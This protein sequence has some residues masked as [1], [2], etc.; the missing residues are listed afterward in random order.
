MTSPTA[1]APDDSANR[2]PRLSVI[3]PFHNE[4]RQLSRCLE[5]L[6]ASSIRDLEVIL[7]DD[8]SDDGSTQIAAGFAQRSHGRVRL[9]RIETN[10][11]P[12]AARNR[13]IA[14]SSGE[15]VAFVDAD[16]VVGERS[17]ECL[18][19]LL[20]AE[21]GTGGVIGTV[22]PDTDGGSFASAYNNLFRRHL[23]VDLPAHVCFFFS[24]FGALRRS[25]IVAAGPFNEAYRSADIE[26]VEYGFRLTDLGIPIA[27]CPALEV[28]HIKRLRWTGLLRVRARRAYY[29]TQFLLD[30]WRV[31]RVHRD[32]LQGLD[33]GF[34]TSLVAATLEVPTLVMAL[35]DPAAF[36][37]V[38]LATLI[39]VETT[40]QRHFLRFARRHRSR[41]VVVAVAIF[42]RFDMWAVAL[43]AAAGGT[44]FLMRTLGLRSLRRSV[45]REPLAS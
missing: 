26:D 37:F 39:L 19:D 38:M 6:G 35:H 12:A 42:T 11:G 23:D 4:R 34:G 45:E 10:A 41:R 5:A 15:V 14:L 17:L 21:P 30:R 31:I 44:G 2:D 36:W 22:S 7:V 16:V 27:L 33:R 25:A 1:S 20:T 18:L 3:V 24:G 43:G 13:G 8:A 40:A 32:R 9:E 28:Q 29:Y